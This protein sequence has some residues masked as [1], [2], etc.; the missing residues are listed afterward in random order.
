VLGKTPLPLFLMT[1]FALPAVPLVTRKSGS[2]LFSAVYVT[3]LSLGQV[4]GNEHS[5]M[6]KEFIRVDKYDKIVIISR[7]YKSH[8][9][10]R[11]VAKV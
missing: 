8:E 5:K 6:S 7:R 9:L 1:S 2:Q 3:I 10:I 11:R 4:I